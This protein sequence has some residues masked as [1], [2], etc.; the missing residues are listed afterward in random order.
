M[1]GGGA[2]SMK[3]LPALLALA[4]AS[5]SLAAQARVVAPPGA[6]VTCAPL[7]PHRLFLGGGRH[8]ALAGWSLR[9]ERTWAKTS[10]TS[11]PSRNRIRST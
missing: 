7:P 6:T 1:G 5:A 3:Y 2:H 9:W 4:L 11:W 10:R 8:S